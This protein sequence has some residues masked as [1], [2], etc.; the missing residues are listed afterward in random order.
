MLDS[1]LELFA[2]TD[3]HALPL[4][5]ARQLQG[6][7]YPVGVAAG[8]NVPHGQFCHSNCTAFQG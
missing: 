6:I 4:S 8:T 7:P 3:S 1:E 5:H 2:A